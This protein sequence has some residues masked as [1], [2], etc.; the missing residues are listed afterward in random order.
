MERPPTPSH[1]IIVCP[2]RYVLGGVWE[3]WYRENCV[4]VGWPPPN[5]SLEVPA[6]DHNWNYARNRLN[7]IRPGDYII[8]CLLEWR[9][10]PVGTVREVRVAD[11]QWNATVDQGA[12]LKNPEEPELGRR[13]LVTWETAGMP[14]NGRCALVPSEQ[15]PTKPLSRHAS[16]RLTAEE[17]RT[18][19]SVLS[20]PST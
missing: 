14:R 3:R 15:R 10:G 16:E 17:F 19:R 18:L 20:N 12:Y 9:I 11:S 7:E 8:P 13:I 4:A 1:W 6:Q 2:Q 5:W